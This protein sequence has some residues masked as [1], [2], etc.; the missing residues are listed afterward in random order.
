MTKGMVKKIDELG[1]VTVP[2]EMR[3]TANINSGDKVGI[4]VVESI[5]HVVLPPNM[6][7]YVGMNRPVDELG[8]FTIP[9]EMRRTLNIEQYEKVDLYFEGEELLIKKAGCHYCGSQKNLEEYKGYLICPTCGQ[10][11]AHAFH[12]SNIA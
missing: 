6:E 9:I 12:V 8:R 5:L 1:R 3:R 2:I 4:Y 11:I 7:K 10:E